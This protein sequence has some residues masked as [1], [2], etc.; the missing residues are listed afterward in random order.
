MCDMQFRLLGVGLSTRRGASLSVTIFC[1]LG[2]GFRRPA[3]F[4]TPARRGASFLLLFSVLRARGFAV[5]RGFGRLPGVELAFCYYFLSSGHGV[6]PSGEVG[7]PVRRAARRGRLWGSAPFAAP[8]LH[9]PPK[10]PLRGPTAT[11]KMRGHAAR[12]AGASFPR[13]AQSGDLPPRRVNATVRFRLGQNPLQ[14]NILTMFYALKHVR[15]IKLLR[16]KIK[17]HR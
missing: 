16:T 12:A 3:R 4:W 13:C 6:S 1:P 8:P 11:I 10:H 14:P 15:W 5:R 9:P 17:T 2:A 7:T